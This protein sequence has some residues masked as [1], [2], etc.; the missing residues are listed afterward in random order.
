[1]KEI[2]AGHSPVDKSERRPA[3]GARL[4][5]PAD[6]AEVLTVTLRVRRRPGAPALPDPMDLAAMAV[7]ERRFLSREEFAARYGAAP[8][9]LEQVTDFARGHGLEVAETNVARRTVVASGTVEQMG[10]AFAVELGRY[11]TPTHSYRGHAGKLQ[12]P[13]GLKDVVEGVFG[14]DNRRMA[15]PLN[16]RASGPAPSINPL[17]PPQVAKLYGFP[18]SPDAAGQTI[19]LLEFGGG[20]KPSDIRDYFAGLELTAPTLVDVGVA[21]ATN[22]PGGELG[23]DTEVA[24]DIDVAGSVARGARIAVYFAPWSE[25]G[26]V[27]AVATAVHDAVNRPSVLSISWGWPEL[28]TELGLTWSRAAIEAVGTIFQEAAVL[29]VTVFAASGD[30]GSGC[31]IGDG[32]AHVLYPASDPLVTSCGGTTIENVS[33][34]SFGQA[35]WND[36]GAT[37]GGISDLFPPQ[38]W[39][40]EA[41]VPGSINDGHRQGRGVPEVGGNADSTSGY[42][43]VLNGSVDGPIGGTS[44]VAPLYAGL[45]ALLNAGLGGPLGYLNPNLYAFAGSDVYREIADG[46]SNATGGAPG[47][48]SGAGWDAC[49]G[50]GSINGAALAAALRGVGKRRLHAA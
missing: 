2:P 26:W 38:S 20:Y 28:E 43:L 3:P 30:S 46:R 27:E 12:L 33:G 36:N 24:L 31:G 42:R 29:G 44:A 17:T 14:L 10:R 47:Y 9:D 21:G 8:A 23:A 40:S 7:G 41:N 16:V 22:A 45:V 32:R 5:G 4:A 34:S 19:G 15:R 6:L 37:G 11:E 50:L 18:S 48:T 35:T 39:Q 49:T 25:Q 13:S 1:M